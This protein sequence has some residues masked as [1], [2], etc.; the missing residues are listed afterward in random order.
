MIESV[1]FVCSMS[2]ESREN[3]QKQKRYRHFKILDGL[4]NQRSQRSNMLD[5]SVSHIPQ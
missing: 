3:L 4:D 5:F 1:L 2:F